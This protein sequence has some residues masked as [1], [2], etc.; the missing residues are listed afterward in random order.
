MNHRSL[1]SVN[2]TLLPGRP[3][4]RSSLA[5]IALEATLGWRRFLLVITNRH[6]GT[7][8]VCYTIRNPV[9][10]CPYGPQK[11]NH[12]KLN[13]PERGGRE[14]SR[15]HQQPMVGGHF[16]SH[17]VEAEWVKY[18]GWLRDRE[19]LNVTQYGWMC[20]LRS[21]HLRT[22][23]YKHVMQHRAVY[24][25]EWEQ[26]G[27]KW[28]VVRYQPCQLDCCKEL[29]DVFCVRCKKWNHIA[30]VWNE[31]VQWKEHRDILTNRIMGLDQKLH[32]DIW[33]PQ[34]LFVEGN[35]G[36]ERKCVK[37]WYLEMLQFAEKIKLKQKKW[38]NA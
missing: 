17:M 30:H 16:M 7:T 21:M 11:N 32:T 33:F 10:R 8:N 13:I 9:V 36:I 5:G 31:C 19:I 23:W 22:D 25:R 37:R 12:M 24:R 26:K 4:K 2:L 28:G 3:E 18:K 35:Y 38:W 15:Y 20:A 1:T 14:E 29:R 34:C 27:R 6:K